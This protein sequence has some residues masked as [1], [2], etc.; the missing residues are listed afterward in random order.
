MIRFYNGRLLSLSD[1]F[2]ISD[3]E[4]WVE[5]SM[6]LYVGPAIG[7]HPP[8]EREIDLRG[9]L[10]MPGF[11]NA[12]AHSA[13]TFFSAPPS[14]APMMSELVYTRKVSDMKASWTNSAMALSSQAAR[15]P[16]GM[17]T[18]TSSAWQGPER[19]TTLVCPVSWA[20]I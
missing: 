16:V 8:F 19:A 6:I 5:E 17:E 11:K 13:M 9:N 14:S 1:G 2:E 18:A 7:A 15:H 10:L 3:W 4:V 12:H 20:T